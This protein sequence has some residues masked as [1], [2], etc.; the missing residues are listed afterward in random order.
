MDI[1]SIFLK[2]ATSAD[3]LDMVKTLLLTIEIDT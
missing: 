1:L 3:S 2:V